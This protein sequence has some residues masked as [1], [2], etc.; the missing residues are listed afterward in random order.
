VNAPARTTDGVARRARRNLDARRA[1]CQAAVQ[2]FNEHGYAATPAGAIANAANYAERTFFRHFAR[3]EDVIFYDLPERLKAL[4]DDF[5]SHEGESAWT[6]V[7][8]TL[9]ANATRWE[10]AD[11]ELTL[12]RVRLFHREPALQARYLEIC[13][14]W[15][16][17]VAQIMSAELGGDPA[18]NDLRCRM[19]A[20]AAVGAFRAAF[21]AWLADP[22]SHIAD[23][24]A[25]A[26]HYIE[27]GL[28]PPAT[29]T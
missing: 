12:G 13:Q 28:L 9:V 10:S 8:T 5:D 6:V 25:E 26:L 1:L 15:E 23:N 29:R 4:Q 14:D 2:L 18:G 21:R 22:D 24:L 16:N 19:I 3:K 20:I 7:R 11:R 27:T 17:I